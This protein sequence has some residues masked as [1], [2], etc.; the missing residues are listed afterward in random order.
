MSVYLRRRLFNVEPAHRAISV[1]VK[2]LDGVFNQNVCQVLSKDPSVSKGPPH[3][4]G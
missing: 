1:D 3:I 2:I 4:Q